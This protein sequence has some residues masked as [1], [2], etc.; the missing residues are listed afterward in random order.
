MCPLSGHFLHQDSS[1]IRMV[2]SP[3]HFLYMYMYKD[4]T[5]SPYLDTSFYSGFQLYLNFLCS[6]YCHGNIEIHSSNHGNPSHI[7][8]RREKG[9]DYLHE[10]KL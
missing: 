4:T 7:V 10:L 2:L 1:Y 6:V 8:F 3:G 9:G 5:L